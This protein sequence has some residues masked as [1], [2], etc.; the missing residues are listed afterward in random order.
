MIISDAR[1]FQKDSPHQNSLT[2]I[3][4]Q[5]VKWDPNSAA[6]LPMTIVFVSK[7]FAPSPPPFPR[8]VE[9]KNGNG[10]LRLHNIFKKYFT[11][12]HRGTRIL[13][14]K[15]RGDRGLRPNAVFLFQVE[16]WLHE[17]K[18]KHRI[19]LALCHGYSSIVRH[20]FGKIMG[21]LIKINGTTLT[22]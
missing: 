2:V 9:N 20:V 22:S 14:K 11:D 17:R 1:I 10:S 3:G 7:Q 4:N 13:Q 15:V 19:S 21:Y 18:L 6:L 16:N 8:R 12:Y 5:K